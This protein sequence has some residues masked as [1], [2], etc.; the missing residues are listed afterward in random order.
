MSKK[1][2]ARSSKRHN[3][4][5]S[6]EK[7]ETMILRTWKNGITTYHMNVDQFSSLANNSEIFAFLFNAFLVKYN[8]CLDSHE[9]RKMILPNNGVT[10]SIRLTSE[11][12]DWQKYKELPDIPI[13][14]E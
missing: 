9:I 6:A 10:L 4:Q 12:G 5:D 2:K 8:G 7:R 13:M 14:M 1:N 3:P 11:N